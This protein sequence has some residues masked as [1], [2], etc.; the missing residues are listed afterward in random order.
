[1]YDR[2][3]EKNLLAQVEKKTRRFVGGP[4]GQVGLEAHS[5]RQQVLGE[6]A[7]GRG[8]L[9]KEENLAAGEMRDNA[10]AGWDCPKGRVKNTWGGS[11]KKKFGRVM[12]RGGGD[13]AR[14]KLPEW[15]G[16]HEYSTRPFSQRRSPAG[17]HP[18]H[19][20]FVSVG[21][22]SEVRG[23]GNVRRRKSE[24]WLVRRGRL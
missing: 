5:K 18:I 21:R 22:I 19:P 4:G 16:D 1:M 10:R 7:R 6:T 17:F 11:T 14:R 13:G 3:E 20:R 2:G 23:G 12:G 24:N 15:E 9:V 8:K